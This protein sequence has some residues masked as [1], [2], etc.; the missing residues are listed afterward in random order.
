MQQ[1]L[2]AASPV[3][4][5]PVNAVPQR[6][7]RVQVS[8][9]P[10][11]L[12]DDFAQGIG[13]KHL[14]VLNCYFYSG[15]R[16]VVPGGLRSLQALVCLVFSLSLS[17]NEMNIEMVLPVGD[18]LRNFIR[19]NHELQRSRYLWHVQKNYDEQDGPELRL[20]GGDMLIAEDVYNRED[21]NLGDVEE[22]E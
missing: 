18:P 5:L 15:K 13:L 22:M 6:P 19:D 14:E 12:V 2:G 8:Q 7:W 16:P 4:I 1:S 17:I 11:S 9:F 21:K 10:R 3:S 20:M